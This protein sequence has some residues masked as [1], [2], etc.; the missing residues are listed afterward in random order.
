MIDRDTVVTAMYEA[1]RLA[2]TTL[3]PD[4][5]AAL[6]AAIDEESDPLARQHLLLSLE[7]ARAAGE[8]EGLVCAD[9]GFPLFFITAG[10]RTEIEGGFGALQDAAAEATARATAESYLRPTMVD[11]LTRENPGDNVGPGM[12]RVRL[13]FEGEGDGLE[14]VAAPKGGGSE[15][16]GTFYRMMYPSDGEAAILK[17][18]ID[19]IRDGCYAGKICPPAIVGVGI[20]GTADLCMEL[21]KEAAVLRPIGAANPDPNAAALERKLFAAARELGVGPMGAAGVGAVMAVNV[22]TAVTHTA[23]LPVA[24]NAQ[25]LVGRR[26]R[27]TI[28]GDGQVTYSGGR[29]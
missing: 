17:F 10:G 4:V 5:E 3:P 19:A 18:V 6:Q 1:M 24:V 27:A 22:E 21:A 26:W 11:P 14:I 7:N 2:A 13:Q 12:P 23:A 16:F 29:A 28:S 15:I 9:T 8:G 25:C 20:G